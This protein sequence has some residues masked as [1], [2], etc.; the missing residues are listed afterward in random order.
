MKTA[1]EIIVT[2]RLIL[3]GPLSSDF[4]AL[5]DHVFTDA[6]V[7]R[8]AF[9]GQPLSLQRAT[10][11]FEE[12]F[13]HHVSGRKLGVLTERATTE[14]IGFAGLLSCNVLGE[15]DFEIGFVLRRSAWGNGYATEIGKGQLEY[16]FSVKGCRR[17]LAQVSPENSASIATVKKLGMKFHSTVRNQERGIR[18]VYV[19]HYHPNAPSG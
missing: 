6:A 14:V 7:M 16:G 1:T 4:P 12:N 19:A 2:A 3:R 15:P 10:E 18:Q 13:D 5:Y 9:A 17:L 8:H 11:F